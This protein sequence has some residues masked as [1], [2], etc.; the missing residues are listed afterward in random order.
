MQSQNSSE[1]KEVKKGSSYG[2][3]SHIEP[4]LSASRATREKKFYDVLKG[5]AVIL[6]LYLL[7]KPDY[8]YHIAKTFDKMAPVQKKG[9][10]FPW[11]I[12]RVPNVQSDLKKLEKAGFINK[13]ERE[14][15]EKPWLK[16]VYC[17]VNMSMFDF[18]KIYADTF[19]P[20]KDWISV[21]LTDYIQLIPEKTKKK[22][23]KDI[24]TLEKFDYITVLLFF[25][26]L[27]T[28][29]V[30]ETLEPYLKE[31]CVKVENLP[32]EVRTTLKIANVANIY[33]GVLNNHILK[34]CYEERGFSMKMETMKMETMKV[35]KFSMKVEKF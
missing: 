34:R 11:A 7:L 27:L 18:S 2:V 5:N 1:G 19:N 29:L 21:L 14:V 30:N 22:L 20:S 17:N 31:A 33:I 15:K 6:F 4:I 32:I 24:L 10:K 35:E 9:G 12:A 28:S 3:S 26:R 23:L 16:R 8:A 25:K 13:E